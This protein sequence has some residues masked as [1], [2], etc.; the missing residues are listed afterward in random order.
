MNE[1]TLVAEKSTHQCPTFIF[2]FA[3]VKK[4][5]DAD[6]LG[7]YKIKDSDYNYVLNIADWENRD[8]KLVAWIQPDSL[9]DTRL[10]QF[11]FLMN[12]AKFDKDCYRGGFYVRIKAKK[13][14][15]IVSYGL[16]VLAPESLVEGDDA[17]DAL[18][19][20]HYN[21]P[22]DD[23]VDA[24]GKIKVGSNETASPPKHHCPDYDLD[25]FLKHARKV[26]V[27]GEI[28]ICTEKIHGENSRFI[29]DGEKMNCGSHHNWKK[30]FASA[31]NITIEGLVAQGVEQERAE[32][33]YL[34]KVVNFK[35]NRNGWWET[36]VQNPAIEKFCRANP[37]YCLYG[38]KAGNIAKMN[39]GMKNGKILFRAFDILTPEG[40]WMNFDD[41]KKLAE[42]SGVEWVPVVYEG[43]FNLEKM[44]EMA[45]M[46]TTINKQT[47]I[48]EGI[49]VQPKLERWDERLGR[50]K[51]KIINPKYLEGDYE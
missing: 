24:N 26:F 33:L 38:E 12:D 8:G 25:S 13:L 32:K 51:L 23:S 30:E 28:S 50:V 31:P 39:Y 43:E 14:R 4:H 3:E 49:V 15:G 21:K 17:M 2:N 47:H 41:A 7:L 18:G 9:A 36:M 48:A 11:D 37:G 44:V 20:I 35:S 40:N 10:P 5:P 16:L 6:R 34:D 42:E 27:D 1:T 46:K 29:F 22:E 19:V 45:N